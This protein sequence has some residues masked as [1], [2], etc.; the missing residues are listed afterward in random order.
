[1]SEPRA[2]LIGRR[3][4][5]EGRIFAVT[6]DTVLLTN[7]REVEMEVVRHPRSVVLLPQPDLHHVV[8]IRQYR[9]VIDRWI[10]ELPAG[11]LDPGE[12]P[13]TAARRE[14]HEEIGQ[15]PR[16]IELVTSVFPTPGFCDE[17]MLFYRVDGLDEAAEPAA[18]DEDEQLEPRVFTVREARSMVERGEIVDMKTAFGLT[19][20]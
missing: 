10:W 14:C 18:G 12:D 15:V 16:R 9:Y 7:G 6:V 4:V 3:V 20:I 8:L 5:H 13:E 11:S 19:L 1:M 2:R 17:E